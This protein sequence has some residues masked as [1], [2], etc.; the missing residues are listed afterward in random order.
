[1]SMSGEQQGAECE[2][3]EAV[4]GAETGDHFRV[5]GTFLSSEAVLL[6]SGECGADPGSVLSLGLIATSCALRWAV[7]S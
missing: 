3:R 2:G 5:Q 7:W 1:M 4:L 6:P